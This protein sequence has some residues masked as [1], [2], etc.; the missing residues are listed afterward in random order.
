MSDENNSADGKNSLLGEFLLSLA[1]A[2]ESVQEAIV[3]YGIKRMVPHAKDLIH[4]Y[5]MLSHMLSI[6]HKHENSDPH[7][8]AS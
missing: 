6:L 7:S 2:P 1:R 3:M 4:P 5:P 8:K